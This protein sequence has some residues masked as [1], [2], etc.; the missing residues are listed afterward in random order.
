MDD[1]TINLIVANI[2][3]NINEI[4]ERFDSY[5]KETS[6]SIKELNEYRIRHDENIKEIKQRNANKDRELVDVIAANAREHQ[7]L[8]KEQNTLKKQQ[9][10]WTGAIAVVVFA[11]Q[12]L[13]QL[14]INNLK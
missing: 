8:I 2:D 7:E 12:Y 13:V 1:K 11:A 10:I 14:I 3:K 5:M 6:C 9:W 4:N